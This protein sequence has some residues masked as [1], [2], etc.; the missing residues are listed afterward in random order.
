MDIERLSR[1]GSTLGGGIK[2]RKA[3]EKL[4]TEKSRKTKFEKII[5]KN[6]LK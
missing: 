4:K 2:K 5:E 6:L 3:G 1:I